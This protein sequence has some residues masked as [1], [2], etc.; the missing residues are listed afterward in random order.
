[1]KK[2]KKNAILIAFTPIFAIASEYVTIIDGFDESYKQDNFTKTITY[3][4]WT[5][6][7]SEY[8]CVNDIEESDV[9]YSK[10]ENQ[11]TDC[12]QNQTREKITTT[13]YESGSVNEERETENQTITNTY[14]QIITGT[15]LEKT[16]KLIQ[17]NNYSEGTGVYSIQ[18]NSNIIEVYCDMDTDG[19]GWTMVASNAYHSNTI[20]KG[21]ARNNSNYRLDRNGVLG[22]ASPSSD[23]IIGSDINN[24][25][26]SEARITMYGFNALS[27]SYSYPNN[28]GRYM[29]VKWTTS[30][31][32]AS[33]RLDSITPVS[34]TQILSSN[35]FEFHALAQY[36]ILDGVRK[37]S[38][39]NANS[40]QATIG[41]AGVANANG[42]PS[43]GTYF[44]HGAN[45][46]NHSIEGAYIKNG[47]MTDSS[48][49]VTWIK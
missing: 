2:F 21:T 24:M 29:D 46:S 1:M 15:H 34:N 33:A 11:N 30:G 10:T 26:W 41:G 9:Y 49:Y 13:V 14:N 25:D 3:T 32:T 19:G 7:G 17:N 43:D 12:K 39:Y 47:S 22:V 45:E 23:F 28:L 8:D 5:N 42:D 27:N 6:V 35:S 36:F 20:A 18:P 31:A 48:G 44:G 38:G 37:D 40:N 16:C 4:N